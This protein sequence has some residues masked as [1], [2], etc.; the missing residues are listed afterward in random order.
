MGKESEQPIF[1]IRYTNDHQVYEKVLKLLIIRENANQ[2]HSE[3]LVHSCYD[4]YY[5]ID[6]RKQ[7]LL[8]MWRKGKSCIMLVGM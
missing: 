2:N 1:L 6:R 3:I 7:L 5:Q 4:A 8:R